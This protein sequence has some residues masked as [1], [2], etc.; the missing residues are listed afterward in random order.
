MCK[1][2]LTWSLNKISKKM[3]DNQSRGIRIELSNAIN[4][5]DFTSNTANQ[6]FSPW[7]SDLRI[8][9]NT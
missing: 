7:V 2:L 5:V 3:E 1:Y 4:R 8:G 6:K 9:Q